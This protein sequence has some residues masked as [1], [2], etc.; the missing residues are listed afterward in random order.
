LAKIVEIIF[1][2]NKRGLVTL[3]MIFQIFNKFE[4]EGKCGKLVV[5]TIFCFQKIRNLIS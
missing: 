3:F 4:Y 2:F 5:G 1:F